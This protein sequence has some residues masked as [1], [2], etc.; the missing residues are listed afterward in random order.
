MT[1]RLCY[2]IFTGK[3]FI[4]TGCI[5]ENYSYDISKKGIFKYIQGCDFSMD[6]WFSYFFFISQLFLLFQQT[7]FSTIYHTVE[8]FSHGVNEQK[9]FLACCMSFLIQPFLDFILLSF[10]EVKLVNL[11]RILQQT[12]PQNLFSSRLWRVNN[13]FCV[14]H[15]ILF[16]I[17]IFFNY[18][19]TILKQHH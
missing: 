18:F 15:V 1:E 7:I 16:E 11:C 9:F 12:V 17:V 3:V 14:L 6:P 10:H 19:S 5:D 13:F 2:I 4:L 8:L